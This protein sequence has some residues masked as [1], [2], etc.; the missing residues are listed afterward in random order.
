M[1]GS[2]NLKY[3]GIDALGRLIKT[4]PEIAIDCL[5]KDICHINQSWTYFL[6]QDPDNTL[7]RKT[8]ELLYKM[9]K[10]S[11]LEVIVDCMID[12]MTNINDHYKAEIASRCVELAEQFAPSNHCFIQVDSY[13]CI[14]GEPKLPSAFLQVICWVFG[15]YGTADGQHS[16]S[17][18]TGKLCDVAE[19]HS[20][21]DT[22]KTALG[23]KVDV[24]PE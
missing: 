4:S 11:N 14:I 20:S 6:T 5:E 24:L 23:R 1:S 22:V 12:Y 15:E 13:L 7:K 17:Y 8:F 19:A 2:H 16:G 18:I 3:M 9:T 10:S 21:D